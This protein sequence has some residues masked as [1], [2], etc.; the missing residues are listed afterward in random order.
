ML[1]IRKFADLAGTTRRT[2]LFYDEAN[3][4]K[5]KK[6]AEN[7]YRYY[8]YDQLYELSFILALRKLGLGVA[9]IKSLLQ[10]DQQADLDQQLQQTLTEI[11]DQVRNLTTLK[12]LLVKRAQA[13][14]S[15]TDLA[16]QQPIIATRPQQTFWR[17]VQ[18]VNCTDE[19]ISRLYQDFYQKVGLLKLIDKQP[20]GFLT[21]LPD[22]QPEGY[23][24]AVFCI[25]KAKTSAKKT[26]VTTLTRPA[27]SY[28]TITTTN[29]LTG[30][31][32][33]LSQMQA[34]L[35]KQG[36]AIKDDLWVLNLG[37]Y[38]SNKAASEYVSLE[39]QLI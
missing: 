30:I 2:L 21:Q 25:I 13:P 7:G 17:S 29:D 6:I 12:K 38:F 11:D 5:P 35:K 16:L 39:Y 14:Q 37:E 23:A 24:E 36:L 3:L 27:G 34:Y 20:S 9:E 1:T 10:H 4:F 8:D 32:T 31:E 26:A 22:C 15:A 18:S 19:E 28:V 33:G